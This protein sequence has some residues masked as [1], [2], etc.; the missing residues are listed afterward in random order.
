MYSFILVVQNISDGC[1]HCTRKSSFR[2]NNGAQKRFLLD[3]G[4]FVTSLRVENWR[5]ESRVAFPKAKSTKV[6][7]LSQ[8]LCNR[9]NLLETRHGSP[10]IFVINSWKMEFDQTFTSFSFHQS[11]AFKFSVSTL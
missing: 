5:V 3:E 6:C 1:F 9:L 11:D 2:N 7:F 4:A 8:H 10:E